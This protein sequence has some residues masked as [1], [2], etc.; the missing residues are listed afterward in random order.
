M[1][2]TLRAGLIVFTVCG[3]SRRDPA[4]APPMVGPRAAMRVHLGADGGFVVAPS[5]SQEA[6][7]FSRQPRPVLAEH[8]SPHG[9]RV[10][11]LDGWLDQSL[12]AVAHD[13]GLAVECAR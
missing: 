1:L 5:P 8:P 11:R 13:G 4:P 12:R 2:Q 3:C 6:A 7:P 10:V 9:G